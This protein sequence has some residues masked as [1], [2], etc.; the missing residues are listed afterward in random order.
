MKKKEHEV[1]MV[2][3]IRQF[4]QNIRYGY[5]AVDRKFISGYLNQEE[6]WLFE[7]LQKS[8]QIHAILVAKSVLEEL[9]SSEDRSFIIAVLLHDIGKIQRPLNI[10]E[11]SL[12]VIIDKLFQK[13]SPF[14][15]RSF[16]KSYRLHGQRGED[17]LRENH[18]FTE[19]PV[20]YEVVGTHHENDDQIAERKNGR[21]EF[22]H[23]LL[24]KH[25]ER[26]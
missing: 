20:F 4:L 26:Y 7:K 24:K 11:K 5:Q 18:V 19:E 10:A 23:N 2:K 25:D 3:R 14:E 13:S 17:L 15:K 8:E 12:A 9:G 16:M 6:I 21:L 22:Y 1:M